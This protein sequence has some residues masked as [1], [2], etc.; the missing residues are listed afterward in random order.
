[1]TGKRPWRGGV[2]ASLLSGQTVNEALPVAEVCVAGR[3]PAQSIGGHWV[4]TVRGSRL[5]L[6]KVEEGR[7]G[8]FDH[9]Q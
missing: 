8:Y 2:S 9:Q 7:R 5:V 3:E 6:Q 4:L 1:M